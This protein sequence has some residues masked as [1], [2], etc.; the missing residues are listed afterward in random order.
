MLP[1]G[2]HMHLATTTTKRDRSGFSVPWCSA[3]IQSSCRLI[4]CLSTVLDANIPHTETWGR[5]GYF[6]FSFFTL[7]WPRMSVIPLTCRSSRSSPRHPSPPSPPDKSGSSWALK[8]EED[9]QRRV[10]TYTPRSE[11][12][13]RAHREATTMPPLSATN[14]ASTTLVTRYTG[15]YVVARLNII[16][17]QH[18]Y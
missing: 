18:A 9:K 3:T 10:K 13:R 11:T 16:H 4:H 14:G 17:T 12:R 1:H 15:L 7:F 6:C 5:G 8:T 2:A